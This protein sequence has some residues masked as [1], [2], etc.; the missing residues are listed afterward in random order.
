MLNLK[1]NCGTTSPVKRPERSESA[2]WCEAS[3]RASVFRDNNQGLEEHGSIYNIEDDIFRA[4]IDMYKKIEQS[5][6]LESNIAYHVEFGLFPL[7]FFQVRPFKKFEF[8]G[9]DTRDIPKGKPHLRLQDIVGITPKDGIDLPMGRASPDE[10][11]YSTSDHPI[12]D[13]IKPYGLL[14]SGNFTYVDQFPLSLPLRNLEFFASDQ[15]T[16]ELEHGMYGIMK[17]A[18]VTGFEILS[19]VHEFL[20]ERR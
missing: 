10:F 11:E 16:I 2:I 4:L 15:L 9:F 5:G 17:R 12:F 14:I 8:A 6:H 18:R 3:W 20:P 19:D 1:N 7:R 13:N